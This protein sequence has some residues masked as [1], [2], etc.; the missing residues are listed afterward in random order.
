M[1]RVRIDVKQKMLTARQPEM[2]L[3]KLNKRTRE[4]V[5]NMVSTET[6]GI[7]TLATT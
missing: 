5:L 2:I 3:K 7:A 6:I 1:A 4:D